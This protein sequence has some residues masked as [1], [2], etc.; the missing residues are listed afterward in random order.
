MRVAIACL[1]PFQ[2]LPHLL[3]LLQ[4][5]VDFLYGT[6]R[7]LRD[8]Q[9]PRSSEDRRLGPFARRHRQHDRL[10]VLQALVVG[11][12]R[13]GRLRVHEA[14]Q[15]GSQPLGEGRK[16]KPT[17][18]LSE[19]GESKWGDQRA[20]RVTRIAGT[21][22]QPAQPAGASTSRTTCTPLTTS[23]LISDRRTVGPP[24]RRFAHALWSPCLKCAAARLSSHS[25]YHTSASALAAPPPP[26]P[27]TPARPTR[28]APPPRPAPLP[29]TTS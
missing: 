11:V 13:L 22:F 15:S 14:L 2:K 20:A 27:A 5:P 1:H 9:P 3:E 29:P 7:A 26:P 10:D 21:R 28:P 23:C 24:E 8:P 17:K 19:L 12:D 4:Q 16:L 18:L 6:P 25:V